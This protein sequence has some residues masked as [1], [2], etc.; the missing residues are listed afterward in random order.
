MQ[1]FFFSLNSA[2]FSSKFF[3][4][5]MTSSPSLT[6]PRWQHVILLIFFHQPF[7]LVIAFPV[8]LYLCL[9]SNG[10][11]P[12]LLRKVGARLWQTEGGNEERT[13]SERCVWPR[14]RV[15]SSANQAVGGTFLSTN[16]RGGD[17]INSIFH[18]VLMRAGW[19]NGW[20]MQQRK[21]GREEAGI[22]GPFQQITKQLSQ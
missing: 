5:V 9:Y 3:F 8:S 16:Y 7:S 15:V 18:Y 6:F 21:E 11:D 4:P 22:N 20:Q 13:G 2:N 14:G 17:S 10:K 1:G 12:R 19:I